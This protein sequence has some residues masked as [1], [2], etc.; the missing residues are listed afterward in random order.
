MSLLVNLSANLGQSLGIH[1]REQFL[2]LLSTRQH[3]LPISRHRAAILQNRIYFFSLI[4]AL[5]VPAWSVL[6]ALFLPTALWQALL[7]IRFAASA[8][9]ALVAWQAR[10]EPSLWRARLLLAVMLAV[11]PLFHLVSSQWLHVDSLQGV[12]TVIAGLYGLLPFVIVAGLTLFPL[13][14][15]EFVGYALPMFLVTLAG[16]SFAPAELAHTV[17]TLWLFILLLGV[18]LFSALNQLRYM[19]SQVNRASYDALTGALTRR[20]GIDVLELQFRLASL[21]GASL[22]LLFFDLDHF[23]SVNDSFGH[24]AGDRVLKTA[25]QQVCKLVRKG[26]SVIRWGGE[27][28]VVVLP[29]ADA[30]EANDVISRIMHTGLGARPDGHPVTAS[31]G[32]SEISADAPSDWKGQVELADHRMYEAKS[33]GR[34]RSIGVVGTPILWPDKP[35]S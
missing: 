15:L 24:D 27:E 23:K 13:T 12:A 3:G 18:S 35:V 34:A 8:I 9:F 29:T 17:A 26:D 1:T 22:S 19:L 31:I 25:S 21:R 6:D 20:A 16:V 14:L 2:E 11:T 4:F 30:K 28:F 5:L 32:V 10:K 33:G 7:G